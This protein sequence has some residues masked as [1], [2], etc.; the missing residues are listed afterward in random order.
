MPKKS[1]HPYVDWRGGRPRFSPGPELRAKGHAARD[2]KHEDGRWLTRGEAVDWS[3]QLL[4]SLKA[5]PQAPRGRPR[6]AAPRRLTLGKMVEAWYGLPRFAGKGGK[7]V[8]PRTV[9]DYKQKLRVIEDSFPELWTAPAEAVT[10]PILQRA[11]DEIEEARGVATARG[12]LV[13]LGICYKWA[14]TRGIVRMT[15]N[16]AHDLD[17]SMPPPRVR[18]A[19]RAEIEALLAAADRL[20][21][22]DV[23]DAIVLG[24]W[25]GQR[26]GDRLA[27]LHH[28][29]RQ[30]RWLFKQSK[31]GALVEVM[32][33]PE[34]EQRLAAARARREAAGII[35]PH[36]LIN[37]ATWQPWVEDTYR[38]EFA[39]VRTEAAS[40]CP[41]VASLHDQDLRD[42]AVTWMSRG[43][44]TPQQVISVT[45]HTLKSAHDILKHYLAT[46]AGMGDSAIRAMIAWYDSGDET[47][48]G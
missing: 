6:K 23:G 47:E 45:G 30:G 40:T 9:R 24:L 20:G 12:A 2:L 36:V 4:A 27:L 44:A 5:A 18:A 35:R 8:A 26:Q 1:P 37:E 32:E 16:P 22:P 21:R 39:R 34:L 15:Y 25:T 29:K 43:G 38:H 3:A 13:V 41:S 19:S 14:I 42:T 11:Y 17:K 10:R 48:S 46:D 31:T 7:A 33:A 28:G